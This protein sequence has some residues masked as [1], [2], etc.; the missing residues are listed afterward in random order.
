MFNLQE[1]MGQLQ[2]AQASMEDNL[3]KQQQTQ[4]S[5]RY[6]TCGS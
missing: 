4:W 5:I 3:K 1:L 6:Q 2:Q